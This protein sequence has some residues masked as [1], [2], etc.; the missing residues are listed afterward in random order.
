[1][2]IRIKCSRA[3]VMQVIALIWLQ[4]SL[5]RADPV[6]PP[7][8]QN[9]DISN[10]EWKNGCPVIKGSQ[11]RLKREREIAPSHSDYC[12]TG[13][14]RQNTVSIELNNIAPP[15]SFPDLSKGMNWLGALPRDD[16]RTSGTVYAI[17]S[18]VEPARNQLTSKIFSKDVVL[19]WEVQKSSDGTNRC[20]S[21]NA[22]T[23]TPNAIT[24]MMAAELQKP[25]R[26]LPL[27]TNSCAYNIV[28]AH[29]LTHVQRFQELQSSF[30]V[31]FAAALEKLDIPVQNKP[32]KIP[33]KSVES[34]KKVVASRVNEAFK[35]SNESFEFLLAEHRRMADSER[36]YA[37]LDAMCRDWPNP[38]PALK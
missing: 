34:I 22:I 14:G 4:C 28:L 26:G 25:K 15:L 36:E 32:R 9:I 13:A 6:C 37:A 18:Y 11:N 33:E 30:L 19:Y 16:T 7:L 21:L 35:A 23:L 24:V 20:L 5:V 17:T 2:T 1:M 38:N 8:P 3:L 27:Q 31:T 12:E 29:E 10:A